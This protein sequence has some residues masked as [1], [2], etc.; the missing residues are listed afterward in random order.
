MGGTRPRVWKRKGWKRI[1]KRKWR[2]D[3]I[4]E[5]EEKRDEEDYDSRT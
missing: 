1:R 4:T 2:R 3:E 5:K